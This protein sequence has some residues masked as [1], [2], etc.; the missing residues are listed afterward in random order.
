MGEKSEE[1]QALFRTRFQPFSFRRLS[2]IPF[3]FFLSFFFVFGSRVIIFA[4]GYL[5]SGTISLQ[6]ISEVRYV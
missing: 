3:R 5:G 4:P 1:A 2:H 6:E